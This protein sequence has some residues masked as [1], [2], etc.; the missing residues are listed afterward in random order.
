MRLP[1]AREEMDCRPQRCMVRGENKTSAKK[2]R[3]PW[4]TLLFSRFNSA[5]SSLITLLLVLFYF[6]IVMFK[7]V[8]KR[9]RK[10]EK[11][12][13]L[14]LDSEMKEILGLQDTDSEESDS[15]S[16][17]G[18][19]NSDSEVEGGNAR[20]EATQDDEELEEE[21]LMESA[22][23]S[24]DEDGIP[25]MSVTEAVSDPLYLVSMDPEVHA[26]ILCPGKLL[27]N[28]R[29]SDVHKSSKVS[30]WHSSHS[31]HSS[32]VDSYQAHSRRFT[33]FVELVGKTGPEGHVRDLIRILNKQ[34]VLEPETREEGA[35]SKRALKRV[36]IFTLIEHILTDQTLCRRKRLLP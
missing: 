7:R 30:S 17:D 13:E 34:N 11:E 32:M 4:W 8:Q 35:L 1:D 21:D 9:Q 3:G 20:I 12:E 28:P 5:V 29:M 2:L 15:G 14:G 31:V 26:C 22:E 6:F 24:E 10:Q 18:S 16:D 19:D 23:G 27:K 33:K 36:R 25:P